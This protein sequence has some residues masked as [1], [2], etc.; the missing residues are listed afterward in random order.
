MTQENIAHM[1]LS[2]SILYIQK[3][4][5]PQE[6]ITLRLSAHHFHPDT[7]DKNGARSRSSQWKNHERNLFSWT[8]ATLSIFNPN[9]IANTLPTDKLVTAL[10]VARVMADLMCSKTLVWYL[11]GHISHLVTKIKFIIAPVGI[12]NPQEASVI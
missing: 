1:F 7:Q 10:T 4:T 6:T 9:S 11:Q 5:L 3:L 12:L 8:T 2:L